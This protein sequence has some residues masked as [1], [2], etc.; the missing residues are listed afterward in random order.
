MIRT[1][2]G[3]VD[4]A[5]LLEQTNQSSLFYKLSQ[6]ILIFIILIKLQAFVT[7]Y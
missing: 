1:L 3:A 5:L 4:S 2:G 6:Y 7:I